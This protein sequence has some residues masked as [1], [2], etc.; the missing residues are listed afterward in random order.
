MVIGL[1]GPLPFKQQPYSNTTTPPKA[2]AQHPCDDIPLRTTS[3]YSKQQHAQQ[4][5]IIQ[6]NVIKPQEPIGNQQQNL[7][8]QQQNDQQQIQ[9]QGQRLIWLK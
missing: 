1:L 6:Q 4:Q 5:P 3:N 9:P 8:P 2:T 7:Q